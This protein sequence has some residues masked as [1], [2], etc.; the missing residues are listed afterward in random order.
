MGAVPT[1]HPVDS[2]D[3]I[4]DELEEKLETWEPTYPTPQIQR[5]PLPSE[6]DQWGEEKRS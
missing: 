3:R 5:D 1:N 6:V 4:L 2:L